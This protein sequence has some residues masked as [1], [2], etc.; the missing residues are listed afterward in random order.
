MSQVNATYDENGQPTGIKSLT[1]KLGTDGLAAEEVD[2]GFFKYTAI[3][4]TGKML[5]FDIYTEN[6]TLA[7]GVY[8]PSLASTTDAALGKGEFS[9][10]FEVNNYG[11]IQNWGTC[12]FELE[13]SAEVAV[14][15][16]LDGTLTVDVKDGV[17]TIILNSTAVN[18][19]YVGK[20]SAE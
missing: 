15:H 5:S 4:G 10:G 1:V 19:K 13:N 11:Q 18:A 14:S 16:V 7:A 12:A 3:T 9:V 8:K 6:G 2:M 20:L 17:Y